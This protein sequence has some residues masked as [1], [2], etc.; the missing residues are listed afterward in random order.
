VRSKARA[1]RADEQQK[2]EAAE[3]E[4]MERGMSRSKL[5]DYCRQ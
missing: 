3:A 1:S 5:R 4:A 2:E